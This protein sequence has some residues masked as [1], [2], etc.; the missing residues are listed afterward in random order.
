MKDLIH[1][2]F[3]TGIGLASMTEE[4][5]QEYVSE[6]INK[7]EVNKQEGRELAKQLIDK[8]KNQTEHLRTTIYE[9][10]E[11]LMGKFKLVSRKEFDELKHQLEKH[12]YEHG[13]G[14]G[15]SQDSL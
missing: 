13:H 3:Y 7:G 11:K 6:L 8:A 12:E 5:I 1:K 14:G 10:F 2:F 4:K 9:E 15:P